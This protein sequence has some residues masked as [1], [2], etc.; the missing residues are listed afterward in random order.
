MNLCANHMKLCIFIFSIFSFLSTVESKLKSSSKSKSNTI[1]LKPKK[2]TKIIKTPSVSFAPSPSK[3]LI[4]LENESSLTQAPTDLLNDNNQ[5]S[6]QPTQ[7]EDPRKATS[8]I[9]LST[10]NAPISIN[11]LSN[12][13]S[14][15]IHSNI[16]PTIVHDDN[17]GLQTPYPS[18]TFSQEPKESKFT[19]YPTVMITDQAV[20]TKTTE[21]TRI[22]NSPDSAENE[23]PSSLL[24]AGQSV[25]AFVGVY[26]SLIVFVIIAG[27]MT[28]YFYSEKTR[29]SDTA[30]YVQ[31]GTNMS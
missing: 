21:N 17:L 2:N 31:F 4:A 16:Q 24:G 9:A 8:N 3:I 20:T 26:L 7:T 23:V 15:N 25:K 22:Q 27:V 1:N 29:E 11:S 6:S 5:A 19:Q 12:E 18:Q 30:V 28:L 13:V 10:T 14:T